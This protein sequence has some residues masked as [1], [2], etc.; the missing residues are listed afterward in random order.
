[1]YLAARAA[2]DL[3]CELREG[4]LPQSPHALLV[5]GTERGQLGLG[6]AR[7]RLDQLV[8]R[9]LSLPLRRRVLAAARGVAITRGVA[10]PAPPVLLRVQ[11]LVR[12]RRGGIPREWGALEVFL[13]V[14]AELRLA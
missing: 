14:S 1:M 4:K 13:V 10:A 6:Q 8:D 5:G 2:H 3:R 9:L 7:A 11:R 12:L